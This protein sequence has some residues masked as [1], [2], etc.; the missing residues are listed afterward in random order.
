[1]SKI[2]T[3]TVLSICVVFAS[4]AKD[5]AFL[6]VLHFND[7]YNVYMAP[8]FA[9]KF[10]DK[11][12]D[13]TIRLFSGDI[14]SPSKETRFFQGTQFH[15]LFPI[16]KLDAAIPGNHEFDLFL[17]QF[18]KLQ[19]VDKVPWV[20]SNLAKNDKSD[21]PFKDITKTFL[22]TVNNRMI[23]EK[24]GFKIGVFATYDANS[25]K[26]NRLART[27]LELQDFLKTSIEISKELR[28]GGCNFVFLL[29]HMDNASDISI[30][31]NKENEIDII[32]GG[33]DHEYKIEVINNRLLL[34]SGFDFLDFSKLKIWFSETPLENMMNK[35]EKYGFLLEE[36]KPKK[37]QSSKF[38]FSLKK[39][40][41]KYLNVE[42][43]RFEVL[44]S[45]PVNN[46]DLT[47][48]VKN[49]VD[50]KV[51]T[52]A[53]KIVFSVSKIEKMADYKDTSFN[54]PIF[55]FLYDLI[56]PLK[57]SDIVMVNWSSYKVVKALDTKDTVTEIDLNAM[58]PYDDQLVILKIPGK[59]IPE[60]LKENIDLK[61]KQAVLVGIT[62]DVKKDNNQEEIDKSSIKIN[63]KNLDE[64]RTYTLITTFHFSVGKEIKAF[65]ELQANKEVITTTYQ[66][67]IVM[68][69]MNLANDKQMA[70]E[71]KC[72]KEKLP[73]LKSDEL[74]QYLQVEPKA[75]VQGD[76][77]NALKTFSSQ[78]DAK[79]IS[80]LL[81]LL[82][83]EVITRLFTYSMV[84]KVVTN[85]NL[86]QS[87]FQI[88]IEKAKTPLKN[89]LRN[90]I[91]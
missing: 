62:Y 18:L 72:F 21:Y 76:F 65:K 88:D 44:E 30:L 47:K 7:A 6:N 67:D 45:D 4:V 53:K 1:M 70:A 87:Y 82:S 58:I 14:Y 34:K 33:H 89:K 71:Y 20:L 63:G 84:E 15:K 5:P 24:N 86:A 13:K 54:F 22:K 48:E 49:V 51:Q 11:S 75:P 74:I 28:K 91:C 43:E 77:C 78:K 32:F 36:G 61:E 41:K 29:T 39:E 90:L 9:K 83:R 35:E 46:D 69:Q 31:E 81:K 3:W 68:K 50:Q 55:R 80:D 64:S 16:I 10:M 42:I 73:K 59:K 52:A 25:F 26:G 12:D 60:I 19:E 85:E 8:K 2:Y 17:P 66:Y 37:D 38:T 40:E 23:I 57:G 79:D 56:R 27:D